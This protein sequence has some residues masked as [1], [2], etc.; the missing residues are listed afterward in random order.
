MFLES[1]DYSLAVPISFPFSK[2]VCD[3]C[4]KKLG[5]VITPDP[6]KSGARNTTEG[7]GRKLNENKALTASKGRFNPYKAKF[8]GCRICKQKV[9]QVGSYYCQPCA[10]KKGICS[11]CG[12]QIIDTKSYKQ[13]ST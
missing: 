11:M 7:G 2:M 6:W 10:Y 13:S 3:N 8:E 4:Q 9:H 5:K 12:K 1:K